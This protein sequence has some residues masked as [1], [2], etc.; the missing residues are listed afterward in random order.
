MSI[1]KEKRLGAKMITVKYGKPKK[2]KG[3]GQSIFVSF[4]YNQTIVNAIRM[5]TPRYWHANDK[6]WELS[7]DSLSELKEL[8]PREEFDVQGKPLDKKKYKE[9][10]VD[11]SITLPKA[12][13]TKLFPYQKETF[14]E[15]MA[16]DKYIYNLQQGLGKSLC[17]LA[18]VVKRMELGQVNKCLVIVAINGLK[19]TWG[20]EI[21]KHL[22]GYNYKILGNRQNSKGVWQTKGS[23]EKLEDLKTIDD[24]VQF[25]ITNIETIRDKKITDRLVKLLDKGVFDCIVVDEVHKCSSV[26][27]QQTKALLKLE[28]HVKYSYLLTGTIL[29]NKP[30]DLYTSLKITG[31]QE[32]N[33]TQFK[34]RYN[35]YGGFGGWAVVGHKHLDELQ[36]KLSSVSKR[37]KK[38]EVLKDLPPK[39][40]KEE[41]IEMG[42]K[43]S[44]I[45]KDV[46]ADIITNIDNISL[47]VDPLAQMIRLRQATAD[48]SILSSTVKE[49]VKFD[50]ALELINDIIESG[51]SVIVFSN[52]ETVISNFRAYLKKNKIESAVV[53]GKITDRESELNKF[54]TKDSCHVILGTVGA[55][56]T[57]YTLNKA[58]NVI[59]L[60]EPWTKAVKE[61]AEDRCHRI[62]QKNN[63]TIYTL[64][65]KD[66][67]DERVHSIVKKKG[68]MGDALVDKQYDLKNPKVLSFLL[69]GEGTLDK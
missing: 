14:D 41:Y 9:K 32:S 65:C 11:H 29:M 60:D 56:G 30:D 53:T 18:T 57:G 17:T 21:E 68:A 48:T 24:D 39:T 62:G 36:A 45:Y 44:K 3:I 50:R 6:V 38:D 43:Q 15:G 40:Y 54:S 51:E 20:H 58:S 25:Y 5:I 31:A 16:Y 47:S 2:V 8:L 22:V 66:T 67:I 10:E 52:W 4:R 33:F 63:V 26:S 1:V 37:L 49:S 13:K 34:Q 46:L 55:L 42:A 35:V 59:F 69:T 23:K 12:L 27:S 19:F 7:Y 28:N 61:Q 64:I